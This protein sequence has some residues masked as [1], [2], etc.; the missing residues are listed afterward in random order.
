MDKATLIK[1][2]QDA[3]EMEEDLVIEDEVLFK[4]LIKTPELSDKKREE[5]E[6]LFDEVVKDTKRHK[7]IITNLKQEVKNSNQNVY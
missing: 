5:I 7:D 1:R 2:L 6:K 4:I 3:E